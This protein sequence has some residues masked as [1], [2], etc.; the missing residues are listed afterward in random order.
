MCIKLSANTLY[1]THYTQSHQSVDLPQQTS[2]INI[3]QC[4]PI[5]K[6]CIDCMNGQRRCRLKYKISLLHKTIIPGLWVNKQCYITIS[7]VLQTPLHQKINAPKT[8][9]H[10]Y[11]QTVQWR[12]VFLHSKRF[13]QWSQ[14]SQPQMNALC[15]KREEQYPLLYHNMLAVVSTS[16]IQQRMRPD[17]LQEAYKQHRSYFNWA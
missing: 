5:Y 14:E 17:E 2:Q 3:N 7:H 15:S 8:G 11:A 1:S 6:H 12:R 16:L 9:Y 13:L 10:M 4:D